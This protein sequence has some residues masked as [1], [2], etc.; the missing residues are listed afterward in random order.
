MTTKKT[1]GGVVQYPE[2]SLAPAGRSIDSTLLLSLQ[3]LTVGTVGGVQVTSQ[4][5]SRVVLS[6]CQEPVATC[7]QVG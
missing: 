1:S 2:P 6:P 3:L 4:Q 5:P 7:R